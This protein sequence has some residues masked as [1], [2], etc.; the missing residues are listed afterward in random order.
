MTSATALTERPEQLAGLYGHLMTHAAGLPN[1]ELFAKLLA[2]QAAGVGALP[3]GLGLDAESFARLL[4]RHFPRC[5]PLLEL[6]PGAGDDAARM[7][8]RQELLDLLLAHRSGADESEIWMASVVVAACMGG[9]HLWQD[10]G[11]WSRRDLSRL[12]TDNFKPLA[13]KNVHDMKWK[14]FLYK[15]LCQQEGIHVCQAPS[16]QVCADYANCFGPED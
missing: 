1:D 15:Q 14:K 5:G 6:H 2:S 7:L 13:D 9:D 8:E 16:C 11:L 10:L 3:A 4:V 12:M